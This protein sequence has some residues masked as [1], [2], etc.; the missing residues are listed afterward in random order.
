MTGYV[1]P[2]LIF[3]NDPE[4]PPISERPTSWWGR[5]QAAEQDERDAAAIREVQEREAAAAPFSGGILSAFCNPPPKSL[6]ASP[7]AE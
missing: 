3:Y 4:A 2:N 5:K 1:P 6:E 7:A